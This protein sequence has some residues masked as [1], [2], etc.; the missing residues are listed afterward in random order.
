MEHDTQQN[1]VLQDGDATINIGSNDLRS[2]VLVLRAINH[3]L[4]KRII[5]LL[6]AEREMTVTEI[7]VAIRVE[8]SIASQHLGILRKAGIVGTRRDGKFIYYSLNQNRLG[9]LANVVRELSAS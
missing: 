9:Y 3:D 1:L 6:G 2:A 8:Q 4:R 7:F 5:D